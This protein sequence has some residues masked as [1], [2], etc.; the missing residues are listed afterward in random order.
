MINV[1]DKIA[2]GIRMIENKIAQ[3][4]TEGKN[5]I[6]FDMDEYMK[7]NENNVDLIADRILLEVSSA[8]FIW[9]WT[10]ESNYY[11]LIKW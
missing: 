3:A 4:M 9:R 1:N 10:S 8:G 2:W 5:A 11:I 7:E 6:L